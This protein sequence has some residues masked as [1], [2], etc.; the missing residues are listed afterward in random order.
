MKQSKYVP[1]IRSRLHWSKI[2][3]IPQHFN[4]EKFEVA[5][6]DKHLAAYEKASLKIATSLAYL[7]SG[8]N[9]IFSS[10]LTLMMVLAAQGVIKGEISRT[11]RYHPLQIPFSSV[12]TMTVGDLVMVNQLV[13][14][15]SLPLN[16]LGSVY[17]ELRQSL[18]DMETLFNLQ[19][20]HEPI[21]VC[22]ASFSLPPIAQTLFVG[23]PERKAAFADRGHYPV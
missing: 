11:G 2:A 22:S 13:F 4:N 1:K 15:L 5:Q 21:A 9:V 17:R 10:A 18:L 23:H 7:N 6:Y 19:K 8:Q 3:R 16:F 20:K 14:Q 12:G